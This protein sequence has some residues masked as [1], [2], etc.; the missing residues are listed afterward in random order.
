[1][2]SVGTRGVTIVTIITL[3]F[4]SFIG[5]DGS[6]STSFDH[7]EYQTKVE[8]CLPGAPCP[9]HRLEI[10]TRIEPPTFEPTVA[11]QRARCEEALTC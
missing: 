2:L 7:V 1:M 10:R 4:V 5:S 11:S 6:V 8:Q 9:I 3:V